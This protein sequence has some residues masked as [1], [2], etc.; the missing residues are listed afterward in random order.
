MDT[1]RIVEGK[2]A[3]RIEGSRY[4]NKDS[5]V[6]RIE[7][8]TTVVGSRILGHSHWAEV[9]SP[10]AGALYTLREWL[11][12]MLRREYRGPQ[13]GDALPKLPVGEMGRLL[14]PDT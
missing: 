9:T 8:L 4:L 13:L 6:R 2:R 14:G 10:N 5:K 1:S 3:W 11:A 7:M 12:L